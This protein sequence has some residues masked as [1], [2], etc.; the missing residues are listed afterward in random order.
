ML[1]CDNTA[2]YERLE[3]RGYPQAKVQ[4]NVQCEIMMVILEEARDSYRC[5]EILDLDSDLGS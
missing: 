5:A 3:R 4:E 2:L 1:Q